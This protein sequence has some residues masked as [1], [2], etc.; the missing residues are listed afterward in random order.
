L[1]ADI[2]NQ[3]LCS[4]ENIPSGIINEVGVITKKFR[5]TWQKKEKNEKH[6]KNDFICP[7]FAVTFFFSIAIYLENVPFTP[8]EIRLAR[9][10]R[11]LGS[12]R[13]LGQARYFGFQRGEN[14]SL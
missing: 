2:T 13:P 6:Y 8:P 5:Q 14:F 12:I 4:L 7:W 10:V 1:T 3:I 11:I 9:L